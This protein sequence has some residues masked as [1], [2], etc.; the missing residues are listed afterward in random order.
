MKNEMKEYFK[1]KGLMR[2]ADGKLMPCPRNTYLL[3][4]KAMYL[5]KQPY[6]T[7][8]KLIGM[9][10]LITLFFIPILIVLPVMGRFFEYRHAK[11]KCKDEFMDF[12]RNQPHEITIGD[13]IC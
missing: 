2:D 10:I 11:K 12:K 7:D 6:S 8:W 3:G 13:G 4:W 9:S 1:D 5:T